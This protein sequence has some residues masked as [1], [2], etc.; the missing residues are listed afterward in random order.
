MHVGTTVCVQ[1]LEKPLVGVLDAVIAPGTTVS[2]NII[3]GAG[4]LDADTHVGTVVS[5]HEDVTLIDGA[6]AAVTHPGTTT[7]V[8]LELAEIGSGALLAVVAVGTTDNS[9]AMLALGTD[10]AVVHVGITV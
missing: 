4:T 7:S 2:V 9:S 6:D 10:A 3:L 5:V 1:L 8:T